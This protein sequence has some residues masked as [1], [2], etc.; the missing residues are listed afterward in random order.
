MVRDK[1]LSVESVRAGVF[2]MATEAVVWYSM[3]Y[4]R[5]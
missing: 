4:V 2:K 5:C 1:C 3:F